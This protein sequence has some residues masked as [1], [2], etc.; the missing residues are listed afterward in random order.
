MRKYYKNSTSYGSRETSI[1]KCKYHYKS[2][3]RSSITNLSFL[4][5]KPV[6][7]Y[8]FFSNP[9]RFIHSL[10]RIS[11]HVLYIFID[12]M[13]YSILQLVY[14]YEMG[15]PLEK[16]KFRIV[17]TPSYLKWFMNQNL[18]QFNILIAGIKFCGNRRISHIFN[19]LW[20][21]VYSICGATQFIAG[22]YFM[23]DLPIFQ[24]GSNI[25]TGAW[26]RRKMIWWNSGSLI[27]LNM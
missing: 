15:W 17:Y 22:I 21:L 18:S 1:N 8:P 2:W 27:I 14:L 19:L 16:G 6:S 24:L 20:G 3:N 10:K 23:L 4:W 12:I 11:P 26:V 9:L 13:Y 7:L 5:Y 25:W